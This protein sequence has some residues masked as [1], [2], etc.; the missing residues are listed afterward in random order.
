M[1][2]KMGVGANSLLIRAVGA[3]IVLLG[4]RFLY[5]GYLQRSRVRALKAQG[6]PI[7][8]HSLL[9]GHLRLLGDWRADNPPDANFYSFHTWLIKNCRKYFPDLDFPPPVVYLDL[10]PVEMQLALVFDPVAA[11]QFTQTPSL[12]KLKLSTD[13]LVPLTSG[14]DIVSNEGIEWK[15]WRSRF[16]PGFSQRNLIAMLPALIEE[17]SIFASQLESLAGSEGKW[18]SVFRLDEKTINLTFDIIVRA[19]LGMRLNEQQRAESSP[20]KIA[21]LDQIRIMNYGANASRALPIGRMPWHN[22]AARVNNKKI[23]DLVMPQIQSKLQAESNDS[24]VKTIVDLAIKYIDKDDPSA[25]RE[26]PNAEFIDKLIANLKAFLF[27]GHD[28]TAA[29]ICFMAKLLQDNTEC[30]AKVRAEHDAVLGPDPSE[31]AAVLTQSPHLLYALPGDFTRTAPGIQFNSA[32]FIDSLPDGRL[33]HV[34]IGSRSRTEPQLLAEAQRV[35]YPSDGH[36]P[37][38]DPLHPVNN[39]AWAPFSIG[40]RNCI[41]MELALIELRIFAVLTARRFD[42]GEAWDKWDEL[43]GSKATPNAKIDGERL[44]SSGDGIVHPKDGMPIHVR[45]REHSPAV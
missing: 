28:T 4:A 16:N 25:S 1:L 31:A 21:L 9:F 10:W 2:C 3:I 34:A 15:T 23:K 5:R 32:G 39:N 26:K 40:P 24:Q 37:E 17:V 20:L 45:L 6:I 18:G 30:M 43:Q 22:A 12:P 38:G 19:S 11:S 27:A 44:Y 35:H 36:V 41:G 33:G 29:T 8:P 13:F 7:L 42:I 14:L